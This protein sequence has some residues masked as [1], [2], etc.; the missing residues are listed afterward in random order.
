MYLIKCGCKVLS[1]DD[2]DP[3][4][5]KTIRIVIVKCFCN[6]AIYV[7]NTQTYTFL[8]SI[9]YGYVV[10]YIFDYN[11]FVKSLNRIISTMNLFIV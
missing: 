6:G 4:H 11:I 2:Q 7:P 1:L 10:Y 9:T 8:L 5:K 3:S